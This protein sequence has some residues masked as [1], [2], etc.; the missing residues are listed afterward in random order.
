ML[1]ITTTT[2]F[3]TL[4]FH[5]HEGF[6]WHA[7]GHGLSRPRGIGQN[8]MSPTL[9]FGR[10]S[11]R[12]IQWFKE[13]SKTPLPLGCGG[14]ILFKGVMWLGGQAGAGNVSGPKVGYGRV[15]EE[16]GGALSKQITWLPGKVV[17]M[18]YIITI[19]KIGQKKILMVDISRS[20]DWKKWVSL[21]YTGH[22]T[23]QKRKF[24]WHT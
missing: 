8:W 19:N 2:F 10:K 9:L 1:Y 24:L 4:V 23:F 5:N 20:C 14:L 16:S 17:F 7:A 22:V 11:R 12:S 18:A 3:V 21:M 6:A 13:N 15:T